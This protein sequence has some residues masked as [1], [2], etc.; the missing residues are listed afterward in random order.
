MDDSVEML[1]ETQDMY[2]YVCA[3]VFDRIE[4]GINIYIEDKRV[5]RAEIDI[6]KKILEHLTLSSTT[7]ITA[8]LVITS[9]VIDIE[10]IGDYCK[11]LFELVTLYPEELEGEKYVSML[12]RV[13]ATIDEL[14]EDTIHC[15]LDGDSERASTVMERH[16]TLARECNALLEKLVSDDEIAA[17]KGIICA[18][19][20]RYLKRISAHICNIASG[21]VNPFHRIGFSSQDQQEQET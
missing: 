15:L 6:R 20:T 16:F 5:N 9:N 7:D 13:R 10:R 2:D 8:S 17:R 4:D 14:F 12:R 19:L 21:V 3:L 1:R 18:L 11:N